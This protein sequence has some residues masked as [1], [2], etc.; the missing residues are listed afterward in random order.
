MLHQPVFIKVS[1][2]TDI[3]SLKVAGLLTVVRNT[4]SAQLLSHTVIHKYLINTGLYLVFP[5]Y[6]DKLLVVKSLINIL[7]LNYFNIAYYSFFFTGICGL[8]NNSKT[9]IGHALILFITFI[10]T[11]VCKNCLVL[12][13]VKKDICLA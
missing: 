10:D 3:S 6:I 1:L 11:L 2:G 4:V 9:F 5:K 13:W 8:I 7:K 12:L